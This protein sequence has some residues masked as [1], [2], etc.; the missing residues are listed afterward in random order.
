M[1]G[2]LGTK[3]EDRALVVEDSTGLLRLGICTVFAIGRGE[4]VVP[5]VEID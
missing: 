1:R 2:Y 4:S 5:L 3:D